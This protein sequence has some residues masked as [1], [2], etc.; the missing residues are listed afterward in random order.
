[1]LEIAWSV[2]EGIIG[3][4][5]YCLVWKEFEKGELARRIGIGAVIGYIYF[6]LHTE[7][8]FP[9]HV[10]TIMSA[11]AGTDFLEGLKERLNGLFPANRK[12]TNQEMG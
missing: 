6:W 2:I 5:L 7:W 9:N 4:V 12:G 10:M 8:G 3:G 1:M 11:Y